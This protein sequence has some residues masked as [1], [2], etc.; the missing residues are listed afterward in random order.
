M[1][2]GD[3]PSTKICSLARELEQLE[4]AADAAATLTGTARDCKDQVDDEPDRLPSLAGAVIT[5]VGC[6]LRDLRRVVR[7]QQDP[8]SFWAI[9]CDTGPVPVTTDDSDVR[10]ASWSPSEAAEHARVARA[11]AG[12]GDGHSQTRRAAMRGRRRFR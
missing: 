8:G 4:R 3:H 7:G 2:N 9:H 1:T 11:Q 5:L 12:P 6:R 10:F